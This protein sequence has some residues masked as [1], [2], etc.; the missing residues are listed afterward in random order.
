LAELGGV[1]GLEPSAI[2]LQALKNKYPWMEV[3]QGSVDALPTLV[4]HGH[5]DLVTVLGVLCHRGVVDP[6]AALRGIAEAIQDRGW[7]LWGDCVYPCLARPHDEFVEAARRF[8]PSQMHELLRA[9]G[10]EVVFSSHFLGW[11]FPVA[12]GLAVWHRL[13]T[14]V[15]RGGPADPAG[16]VDDRP[17]PQLVNEALASLTY[18]EWRASLW[19]LKTPLGVSRLV[20]ARKSAGPPAAAAEE[21]DRVHARTMAEVT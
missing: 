2:A 8:Y 9:S 5:F 7:I 14:A 3:V 19:G 6:L 15:G 1:T 21:S 12:W 16:A 11:G 13:T 4:P 18:W 17:L 10:F 20:L